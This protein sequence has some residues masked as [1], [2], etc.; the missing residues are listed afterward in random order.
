[1]DT[2]IGSVIDLVNEKP[3]ILLD[4]FLDRFSNVRKFDSNIVKELIE[5]TKKF[6]QGKISEN[7]SAA[8]LEGGWYHSLENGFPDYSVYN[9][10]QYF[11]EALWC[12]LGYSRGYLKGLKMCFEKS[13]KRT[14]FEILE[15][16]QRIVDL[17]CGLGMTTAMLSQLFPTSNIF[18]TNIEDTEQYRFCQQLENEFGFQ[19]CSDVSQ[20][21]KIDVV[22]AFEYFEHFE[23]PIQHLF[24][25]VYLLKPDFFILANSFN[26]K[27]TGHFWKYKIQKGSKWEIVRSEKISRLFNDSLRKLG[28]KMLKTTFWNNRPSVWALKKNKP[29]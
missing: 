11:I 13:T 28:Y 3:G 18:G 7:C 27:A 1:M 12:W 9:E 21:G 26:T 8:K 29:S 10:F 25:V 20:L 6:Y 15:G 23:K 22:F 4:F 2:Q 19:M 24:E 14:V 17:G 5:E 16:Q